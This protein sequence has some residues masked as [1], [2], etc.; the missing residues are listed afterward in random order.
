VY[1]VPTTYLESIALHPKIAV[2]AESSIPTMAHK[3]IVNFSRGKGDSRRGVGLTYCAQA[4]SQFQ[5]LRRCR[6]PRWLP[7]GPNILN[8]RAR[9]RGQWQIASRQ[10]RN[11]Q[12]RKWQTE[13]S[14]FMDLV[15]TPQHNPSK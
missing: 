15:H 7:R 9:K 8:P 2:F 11:G 13:V 5:S 6:R 4:S 14:C 10:H 3:P 12:R 1:C